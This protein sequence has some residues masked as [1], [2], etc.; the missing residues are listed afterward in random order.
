MKKKLLKIA[1]I[2]AIVAALTAVTAQATGF[3]DFSKKSKT[4]TI[5]QEEY[6]RL[7]RFEKLDTMLQFV[8]T[9]YWKEP[10][11][12]AML[13]NAARALMYGLDD[14]YTF[15]YSEDEW[16]EMNEWQ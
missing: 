11:V 13:E 3:F 2:I 16:Q 4:V 12:D 14:P 5:T 6:D 9:Y 7:Q 15:Y 1:L 8:E 10:D